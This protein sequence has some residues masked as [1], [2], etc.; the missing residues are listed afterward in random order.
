M[1]GPL[2]CAGQPQ[3][4]ARLAQHF[5]EVE[6]LLARNAADLLDALVASP[7]TISRRLSSDALL[8]SSNRRKRVRAAMAIDPSR[9]D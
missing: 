4:D 1:S 9:R 3:F 2:V 6:I 7:D 8:V 5:D